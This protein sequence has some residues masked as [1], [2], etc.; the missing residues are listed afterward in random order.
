MSDEAT[1]EAC[2]TVMAII[3]EAKANT[4]YTLETLSTKLYESKSINISSG[5]MR[6]YACGNKKMGYERLLAF[7]RA[8]DSAGWAGSETRAI[9][10]FARLL[11]IGAK[12]GH[13]RSGL[14][15]QGDWLSRAAQMR[16]QALRKLSEAVAI[17]A[18]NSKPPKVVWEVLK[19]LNQVGALNSSTLCGEVENGLYLLTLEIKPLNA[20]TIPKEIV[21][22]A[23]HCRDRPTAKLSKLQQTSGTN[24]GQ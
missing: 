7:A 24:S 8:I 20:R 16:A 23:G 4:G 17:L 14:P 3:A 5:L 18:G 22:V 12:S 2:E 15:K 1:R 19:A 21:A 11:E 13:P 10:Q 9:L 6:Q